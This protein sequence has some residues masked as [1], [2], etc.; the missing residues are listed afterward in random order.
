MT[1]LLVFDAIDTASTLLNAIALWIVAGAFVFTVAIYTV[2]LTGVVTW[3]AVTRACTGAWR[4]AHAPRVPEAAETVPEP[5]T[6][7]WAHTE[8]EA[9]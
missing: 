7:A 9:A 6:P 4:A 2:I 5:H 8:K 3:R 1:A